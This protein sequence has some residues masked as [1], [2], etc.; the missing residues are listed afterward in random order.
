[1][2]R[3]A[4]LGILGWCLLL[5]F[6]PVAD[7]QAR[8]RPGAH[9]FNNW[10]KS[11]Y[12]QVDTGN[13]SGG[14]YFTLNNQGNQRVAI[15]DSNWR[16]LKIANDLNLVDGQHTLRLYQGSSGFNLD[17]IIIT[18]NPSND[19]G[20]IRSSWLFDGNE[21]PEAT[22]GSAT[23]EAC[24]MCNPAFGQTVSPA[25]CS[26]KL[27]PSDGGTAYPGGGSGLGCTAVSTPTDQL[28]SDLFSDIAPLR[29][30]QEAAKRLASQLD[31]K[32]DQIGEVAFSNNIEVTNQNA[33]F[34]LGRGPRDRW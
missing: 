15:D 34:T 14:P 12:W 30:A 4:Y 16:W 9:Q 3:G 6:A 19:V 22:P 2:A 1:M 5:A 32:F 18:N 20:D 28:T 7:A 33:V 29:P 8:I 11:I 25:Q 31:P 27:G 10:R 24:D 23:R 17:K 21:G 26:C 13:V